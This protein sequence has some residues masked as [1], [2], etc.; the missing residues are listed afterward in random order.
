MVVHIFSSS[1]DIGIN[2][3][4]AEVFIHR[5]VCE[6]SK[7]ILYSLGQYRISDIEILSLFTCEISIKINNIQDRFL[8]VVLSAM[9]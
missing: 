4:L 6:A 5:V 3:T 7:L 1:Y 9:R 2:N 8:I